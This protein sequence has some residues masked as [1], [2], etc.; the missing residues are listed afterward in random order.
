M[1]RAAP[2]QCSRGGDRAA[3]VHRRR[4][5]TAAVLEE[6][7]EVG[8]HGGRERENE[9]EGEGHGSIVAFMYCGAQAR[10]AAAARQTSF[11]RAR[12]P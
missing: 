5:A 9:A 7:A 8:G 1:Q 2:P 3:Q 11:R 12:L 6:V 4:L 10:F